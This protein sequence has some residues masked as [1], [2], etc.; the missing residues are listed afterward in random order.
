MKRYLF[1]LEKWSTGRFTSEVDFMISRLNSWAFRDFAILLLVRNF[2]FL[3][4]TMLSLA[5][6]GIFMTLQGALATLV[7]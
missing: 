3:S 6:V 1:Q 7:S 2:H 5:V 4:T